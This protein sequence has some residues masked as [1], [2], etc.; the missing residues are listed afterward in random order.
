MNTSLDGVTRLFRQQLRRLSRRL[1]EPT[2]ERSQSQSR[3]PLPARS[4]ATTR[5]ERQRQMEWRGAR[6]A[7]YTREQFQSHQGRRSMRLLAAVAMA[8]ARLAA[9]PIAL[10]EPLLSRHS[11][12]EQLNTRE[13]RL[14]RFLM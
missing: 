6:T 13:V 3:I 14:S 2:R 9:T 7:R 12:W 10:L 5:P 11:L 4:S 8:T 1:R